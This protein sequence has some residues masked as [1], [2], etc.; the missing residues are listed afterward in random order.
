MTPCTTIVSN[1]NI[2]PSFIKIETF[3]K[4]FELV[5]LP[6]KVGFSYALDVLIKINLRNVSKRVNCK[7]H[8]LIEDAK[9]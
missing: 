1:K 5:D 6:Q 3:N 8:G 4:V 7:P 9:E 2:R